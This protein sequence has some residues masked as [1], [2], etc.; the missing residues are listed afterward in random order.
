MRVCGEEYD[1]TPGTGGRV[2]RRLR[3]DA[4]ADIGSPGIGLELVE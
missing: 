3:L 2:E 4:D 1:A